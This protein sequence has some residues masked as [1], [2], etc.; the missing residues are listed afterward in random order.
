MVEAAAE[1]SG[2]ARRSR[3][4]QGAAARPAGRRRCAPVPARARRAASAR[5]AGA[6]K[7]ASARA[8][9][10]RSTARL[11]PQAIGSRAPGRRLSDP[12]N[13]RDACSPIATPG[14]R[15]D[16]ALD[17][18]IRR[19]PRAAR[20][21][22]ASA[23]ISNSPRRCDRAGLP[24]EAKAVLDEGVSRGMLDPAE[25]VVAPGNRRRQ[26]P[27]RRRSRRP[28][29]GCAPRA[30]AARP[31]RR[32]APP[33]TPISAMANMPRPPSSIA[34]H[35]RRAARTPIWSTA[36]SARRWRSPASGPRPKRRC[37]P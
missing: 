5:P 2:A 26:P 10:W 29:R 30:L 18:D 22:P 14:R 3:P 19:L 20:R 12:V 27:R 8:A 16:P 25:P 15:A 23:T 24:G 11:A 1:Q 4:V 6:G 7:L 9:R 33:A 34:P 21:W 32:R 37:A 13:W 31:A 35:C 17:L 28:R 36:G